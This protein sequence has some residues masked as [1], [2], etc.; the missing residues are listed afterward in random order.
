MLLLSEEDKGVADPWNQEHGRLK[1][2]KFPLFYPPHLWQEGVKNNRKSKFI[3]TQEH[4]VAGPEGNFPRG[5][6]YFF[7]ITWW[8]HG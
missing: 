3:N 7:F 8:V 4:L 2:P 1:N 6:L 5:A